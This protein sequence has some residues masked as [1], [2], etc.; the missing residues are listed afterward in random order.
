MTETNET[1]NTSKAEAGT[2]T[3][4]ID[5][6]EK[7]I[8]VSASVGVLANNNNGGSGSGSNSKKNNVVHW[9]EVQDTVSRLASHKGVLAV[10]I[11]NSDGD[12]VT[13]Q[14][15]ASGEARKAEAASRGGSNNSNKNNNS[16]TSNTEGNN[17][18]HVLG[19]PRLLA[20]MMGAASLYVQ[21]LAGHESSSSRNDSINDNETDESVEEAN[22]QTRTT[23]GDE[24]IS[25][26]RIRTQKEEIL[27]APKLGYT[28]VALQ[29]PSVSS[30]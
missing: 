23:S 10:S 4:A 13:Q 21:S 11:L 29:D 24:D 3:D 28:L 27:V 14:I 8:S 22:K 6:T 26:V 12:I 15:T 18:I 5:G 25:F 1:P 20:K 7:T 17:S 2:G 16:T 9:Q 19:N 30:L